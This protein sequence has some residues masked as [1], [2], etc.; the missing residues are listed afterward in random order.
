MIWFVQG[1]GTQL[2]SQETFAPPVEGWCWWNFESERPRGIGVSVSLFIGSWGLAVMLLNQIKDICTYFVGK[3][4]LNVNV[5]KAASML[6]GSLVTSRC[7][8]LYSACYFAY[9]LLS[10]P[11]LGHLPCWV[12]RNHFSM[13]DQRLGTARWT[14]EH[15]VLH[16]FLPRKG[17]RAYFEGI[18]THHWFASPSH[19]LHLFVAVAWAFLN[20]DQS[21]AFQGPCPIFCQ[22]AVVAEF[23]NSIYKSHNRLPSV[24]TYFSSQ[25]LLNMAAERVRQTSSLW[26][27]LQMGCKRNAKL[28]LNLFH[29]LLCRVQNI[30]L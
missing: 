5:V 10:E 24:T 25:I 27:L 16:C 3:E 20:I 12:W 23:P 4:K 28:I 1:H 22:L 6:V 18:H 15:L 7:W 9:P 11:T 14:V 2:L 30:Q 29:S 13:Q 21:S 19:L 8:L 26:E 17:I